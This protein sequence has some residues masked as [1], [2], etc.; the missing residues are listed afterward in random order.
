[1]NMKKYFALLV[2][3]LAVGVTAVW[4]Y[5]RPSPAP[6]IS[7][8]PIQHYDQHLSHWINLSDP[9]NDT[10]LL[11]HEQQS[12]R[13]A[14]WQHHY[15]GELSPWNMSHV[16]ETLNQATP[17]DLKSQVTKYLDKFSNENK[18]PR[19]IGY[20]VNF[21]PLP[22]EWI[23][24]LRRNCNLAQFDTLTPEPTHRA[25]AIA[26]TNGRDLPT[27]EVHFY[28]YTYAGEGYPFDNLQNAVVWA[29]TPLY[30]LGETLN[31][32]WVLV[33][34]PN[35][36]AW[37]KSTD[38][39]RVDDLFITR[40]GQAATQTLIA[41]TDTQISITD[42]DNQTFWNTGY[43]GMV[44][45]G[46]KQN[47]TWR[48]MIPVRDEH[49]QARI[50]Y[51][52]LPSNQASSMPIEATPR[53]FVAL[54]EKLIGRPY[55]WGGMYF[56]NDC[57]SEL[58][59]L[60]TPFG[61]WLP[62][63]SSAQVDPKAYS[64]KITDLSKANRESRMQFLMREGHPFMTILYVGHHVVLYLGTYP[65]PD[66]PQHRPVI[67]SYQNVWKLSPHNP[68]PGKDRR[69]IIGGSVLLPILPY[70]PEDPGVASDADLEY[71]TIGIL[72][73]Q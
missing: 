7:L 55:G 6:F 65:N 19:K 4:I 53:H 41:I 10:P 33:E 3:V 11:T 62:M 26:N 30:I 8:F 27:D 28:H 9:H 23:E 29:G 17:N 5:M 50:H 49:G 54:L 73:S 14:D 59:N 16:K 12:T 32:D 51:A 13:Y 36:I 20:G 21:R 66:D 72:D 40:W 24:R 70:Y 43:I 69:S 47:N 56:Y 38:I 48:I 58:K 57:A 22:A 39:A 37:L 18:P 44:F 63:Q 34:S 52:Q 68:A 2:L 1:M 60:Y 42:E 25:I 46:A 15:Y 35:F 31:H 64:I 67:L 45:P 71:F 61:I